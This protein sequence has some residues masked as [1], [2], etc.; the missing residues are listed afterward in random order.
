[1]C[2]T[3]V[4]Q[5]NLR[6]TV[7]APTHILHP[8]LPHHRE[9]RQKGVSSRCGSPWVFA[10]SLDSRGPGAVISV[11]PAAMVGA[12]AADDVHLRQL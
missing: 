9:E 2:H 4:R 6:S 3:E 12:M 1:M 10:G 8:H 5:L 7:V 11:T